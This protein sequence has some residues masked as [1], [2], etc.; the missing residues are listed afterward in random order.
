MTKK[1]D[2]IKFDVKLDQTKLKVSR[3]KRGV[4]ELL[5]IPS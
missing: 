2:K 3:D 1:I 5:G 4:T